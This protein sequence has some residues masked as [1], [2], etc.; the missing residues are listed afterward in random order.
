GPGRWTRRLSFP[1]DAYIEYAF[2]VD[3]VRVPDPLNP[4]QVGDGMEHLN[5]YFHMPDAVDT[6]LAVERAGVPRGAITIHQVEGH[7][8]IAGATRTVRLYQPPVAH[9]VPLLVVLD[10][11]EYVNKAHLPT[12][13]DNLIAEQRIAPLAM[14]LIDHGDR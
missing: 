14:A 6:P 8:H 12:I 5:S 2:L 7:G 9:P 3:G 10:G 1:A 13:V 4:R 11:A